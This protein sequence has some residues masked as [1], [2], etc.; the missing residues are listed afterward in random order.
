MRFGNLDFIITMEG[1]LA[2]VSAAIQPLHSVGLDAIVEALEELQLH[3][4]EARVPR[5]DKLLGFDYRRLER[6]L[7]ALLGPQPSREDVR[8]LTFSF[9]NVMVQLDRGE[10]LSLE[11]LTRDVPIV[12]P[13]AL[14][15][16]VRTVGHLAVQRTYLPPIDEKFMGDLESISNSDSSRRSHHPS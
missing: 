16:A 6:Q 4:S 11:Y 5:S 14:R 15:N 13:F 1:E 7:D 12:F 3:V 2:Q 9:T 10:P 8:C